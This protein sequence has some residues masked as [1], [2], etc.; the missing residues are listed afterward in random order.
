MFTMQIKKYTPNYVLYNLTKLY[1]LIFFEFLLCVLHINNKNWKKDDNFTYIN[2][3]LIFKK[4]HLKIFKWCLI[5]C[6]F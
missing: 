4:N 6:Q 5:S 3:L 1:S 2:F